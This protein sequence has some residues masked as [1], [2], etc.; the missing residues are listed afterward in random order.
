MDTACKAGTYMQEGIGMKKLILAVGF[1]MALFCAGAKEVTVS[2]GAGEM[3]AGKRAPQFAVWLEDTDGSFKR[4][5]FVTERAG[6]QNWIF[7]P[8]AGRPESLPVW[9]HASKLLGAKNAKADTKKSAGAHPL[10]VVTSATPKGGIIFK[11]DIGDA[12][13]RIRAEF[14]ASFDYNDAYPKKTSGVNGQPSLVYGADIPAD[15]SE[16]EIVLSLLGTGSV[17]GSDGAV[18]ADTAK[19]SSALRIVK[20]VAVAAK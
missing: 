6:K 20:A 15:F 2:V 10:D 9:Y 19:L 17:D 1:A 11:A 3:W 18:H 8:K 4:T 7:S 5:L 12:P 13:C 14:N 16:G